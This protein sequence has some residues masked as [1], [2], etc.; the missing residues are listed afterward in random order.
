MILKLSLSREGILLL[1]INVGIIEETCKLSM[2]F[3][4]FSGEWTNSISRVL[5]SCIIVL[6]MY[7]IFKTKNKQ[8]DIWLLPIV[9]SLIMYIS[10]KINPQISDLAIIVLRTF[11]IACIPS[12]YLARNLMDFDGLI[13]KSKPYIVI[14]II[15]LIFY[16][17]VGEINITY[18]NA[19][20]FLLTAS[21][22][23]LI[24]A[25]KENRPIYY[26]LF[27][28]FLFAILLIGSRG[29]LVSVM[30]FVLTL[31]VYKRTYIKTLLLFTITFTLA[32]L[33]SYYWQDILLFL[34]QLY[35]SSRIVALLYNTEYFTYSGRDNFYRFGIAMVMSAPFK[36]R[37]FLA[38]RW[39]FANNF[40]GTSELGRYISIEMMQGLYAHNIWLEMCIQFGLLIGSFMI[41]LIVVYTIKAYKRVL[42]ISEDNKSLFYAFLFAITTGIVPLLFSRS[43][44]DN[45]MFW[46][47]MGLVFSINRYKKPHIEL[48]KLEE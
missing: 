22:F 33:I 41:I 44:L 46:L 45:N 38:D 16:S 27:T 31:F 26:V 25:L 1:L 11:L 19:S 3:F 29:A 20:Y 5:Y 34:Y 18:M 37:G 13:K 23:S 32:L 7:D 8:L 28:L 39:Y 10:V 47:A 30:V 2:L 21:L 15:Y 12:Y 17:F 40:E 43:Y 48:Q 14:S 36:F 6:I 4:G 9:Y 35:P 24:V 42:V